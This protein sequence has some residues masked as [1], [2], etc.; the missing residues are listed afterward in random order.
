MDFGWDMEMK[1][2]EKDLLSQLEARERQEEIFWKQKSCVKWL[3]EGD[4]NTKLFHSAMVSNQLG[5]NI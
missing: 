3:R 2:K 1:E 4:K 5:S